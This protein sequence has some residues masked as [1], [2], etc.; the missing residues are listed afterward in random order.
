MFKPLGQA[1]R[2]EPCIAGKSERFPHEMAP[3]G[4]HPQA[5]ASAA[6]MMPREGA[7]P[8]WAETAPGAFAPS[9]WPR[10]FAGTRH[11]V[12]LGIT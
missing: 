2:D 3:R 8:L 5:V 10:C 12:H 11:A 9:T 7:L 4:S 6:L 1:T